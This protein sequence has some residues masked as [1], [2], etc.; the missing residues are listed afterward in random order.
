METYTSEPLI[1]NRKIGEHSIGLKDGEEI[2]AL[3]VCRE[4]VHVV[5]AISR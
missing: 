5:V 4:D 2:T 3:D 1:A